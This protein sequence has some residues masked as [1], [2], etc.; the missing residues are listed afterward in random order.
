MYLHLSIIRFYPNVK[1]TL[2]TDF[3]L[4]SIYQILR[5]EL[6]WNYKKARKKSRSKKSKRSDIKYFLTIDFL[7][8]STQK[9]TI[10]IDALP[11]LHFF[12]SLFAHLTD[13]YTPM[14]KLYKYERWA[15]LLL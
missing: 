1:V 11:V 15:K 8:K 9:F 12:K 2:Q 5:K 10:V 13:F 6:V 14:T 3:K 4:F 7:T